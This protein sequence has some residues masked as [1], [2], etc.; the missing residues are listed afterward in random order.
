MY[1]TL[2]ELGAEELVKDA[3]FYIADH[4]G[5]INGLGRLITLFVVSFV[6]SAF[7]GKI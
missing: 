7:I 5:I 3:R 4:L 1:L 6:C 2:L